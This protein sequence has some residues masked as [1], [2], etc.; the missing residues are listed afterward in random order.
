[1]PWFCACLLGEKT[2]QRKF[3]RGELFKTVLEF[4]LSGLGLGCC[5]I[6]PMGVVDWIGWG[7]CLGLVLV[8][9]KQKGSGWIS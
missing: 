1:M 4:G 2:G 3:D 6:R 9:Y 7:V 8:C 5:W